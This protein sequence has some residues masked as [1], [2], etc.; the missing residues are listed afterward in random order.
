[1]V[2]ELRVMVR[3]GYD[4]VHIGRPIFM[5]ASDRLRKAYICIYMYRS[6]R[7][8]LHGVT[9]VLLTPAVLQAVYI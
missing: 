5:Y 4:T 9:L 8:K 7:T 1:M 6:R 3:V 2:R